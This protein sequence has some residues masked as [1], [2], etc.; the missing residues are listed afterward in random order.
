[1]GVVV[2]TISRTGRVS[3]ARWN[4]KEAGGKILSQGKRTEY[5]NLIKLNFHSIF[6]LPVDYLQ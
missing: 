1:M 6:L 3:I 4:L 2:P 5:E